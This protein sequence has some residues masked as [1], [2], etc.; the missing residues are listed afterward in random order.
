MPTPISS[1][2]TT[3]TTTQSLGAMERQYEAQ[4]STVSGLQQQLATAL[5]SRDATPAGQRAP[6][7]KK[8]AGL[9][10][11]LDRAVDQ[12][13]SLSTE[14]SKAVAGLTRG[15]AKEK[16]TKL[17]VAVDQAQLQRDTKV[18]ERDASKLALEALEA[19]VKSAHP[20]SPQLLA[21]RDATRAWLKT[22]TN[23]LADL[24]AGLTLLQTRLLAREGDTLA[25]NKGRVDGRI[26]A[27]PDDIVS[28]EDQSVSSLDGLDDA[29]SLT[30]ERQIALLGAPVPG[31]SPQ[32]AADFDAKKISRSMQSSPDYG[33]QMLA[34][35]LHGAS[36]A[37]QLLLL[38]AAGP[39]LAKMVAD[40]N[41]PGGSAQGLMSA[42]GEAKGAA[43]AQLMALVARGVDGPRSAV[44]ERLS[45]EYNLNKAS[46]FPVL[47]DFSVALRKAGKTEAATVLGVQTSATLAKLR[48]QFQD[49]KKVV[50]KL[51]AEV[52]RVTYGFGQAVAP[53]KLQAYYAEFRSKH[54]EEYKAYEAA[55][56]NYLPTLEAEAEGSLDPLM[57]PAAGVAGMGVRTE[58]A[59]AVELAP[60]LLA[61][62]AGARELQHAF[63]QQLKQK[64]NWLT[65]LQDNA[66][67]TK[68]YLVDWPQKSVNA[69]AK[70]LVKCATLTGKGPG[71]INELVTKNSALLGIPPSKLKAYTDALS[72]VSNPNLAPHERLE[73]EKRAMTELQ[74][75]SYRSATALGL[76]LTLP[77]IVNGWVDFKDKDTI[78]QMKQVMDTGKLGT[79]VLS[80]VLTDAEVLG[81]ISAVAGPISGALDV[82]K[83]FKQM[84]A[85]ENF[86]G[87]MN[88][89]TGLGATLMAIP[90]GQV[91]GAAV[92]IGA[93]VARAVFGKNP[94]AEAEHAAEAE[95]QRFLLEYGG[96]KPGTAEALSDV[97]RKDL[98]SVGTVM[99]QLAEALHKTPAELLQ[100][101]DSLPQDKV[102]EFVKMA[103]ELPT[104][105]QWH[106]DE[107]RTSPFDNARASEFYDAANLYVGPR[108]IETAV[109]WMK[110]HQVVP[111]TW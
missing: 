47:G 76:I 71:A 79:D 55:A 33:A 60:E 91:F 5:A 75:G 1:K 14:L 67:A 11:Q 43:R 92:I 32:R 28:M 18:V 7:E 41:G 42:M 85:G 86:E 52:G 81:K 109:T 108:S 103:K 110:E 84:W 68:K 100:Q 58:L 15:P 9:R 20:P 105:D 63:D 19:K 74:G 39:D 65:S 40:Q 111:A 45:S 36:E 61:T 46:G 48:G 21:K 78:D 22:A 59:S 37:Q 30:R 29:A 102:E 83:G 94:K 13:Q 25:Q 66:N 69:V 10:V 72:Q 54:A 98:R 104:D 99:P 38:R 23:Q 73:L 87:A 82:A 70:G 50:D 88:I 4:A 6:L 97:L 77:G 26:Q 107:K 3:P 12:L 101:L 8:I 80:F 27:N 96:L 44:L 35:Q 34:M 2:L 53:E 56:S 31:M 95:T 49:A 64:P 16:T 24:N 62:Q 89:Y 51:D 106:Y 17:S 93:T 90:G 57:G